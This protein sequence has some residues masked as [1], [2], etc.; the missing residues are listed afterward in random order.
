MK[1]VK[2]DDI[3]IGDRCRKDMGDIASLA[4][5]IQEVGLLQPP[6][7]TP[8]LQLVAGERRLSALRQLGWTDVPVNVAENLDNAGL[9]LKAERD[10]NIQR[11]GLTLGEERS[12]RKKLAK[13]Y[14]PDADDRRDRSGSKDKETG[15]FTTVGHCPD[16]EEKGRV[17]EKVDEV[18]GG[19][20]YKT[21]A[22]AEEV[23]V[24]A[25]EDPEEW[26]ELAEEMDRTGNAAGA[27]NELKKRRKE[28]DRATRAEA[29]STAPPVPV[30]DK[31]KAGE[32]YCADIRKLDLPEASVGLVFTD[33]PYHDEYLDLYGELGRVAAKALRPGG[34]CLSY[35]GGM[36][37][38]DVVASLC[39]A[40]L[41]YFW[42]FA[43]FHP[44]SKTKINRY[45]LFQNWRSVLV[46][47]KGDGAQCDWVQDVVRG[48]RNKENHDWAQDEEAP[49]QYI[50][51]YAE[52]EDVVL[53]P[54]VGG[55]TTVKVCHDIGQP[56]LGFDIDEQNV[57]LTRGGVGL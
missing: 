37:L 32:V 45:H 11:R 10:E 15:R 34:F 35:C 42:Q 33:P 29:V 12:V 8:D 2:I 13:I 51:V 22:R 27:L 9:L 4:N 53:D 52:P 26:G 28:E 16:V 1:T 48:E 17:R 49:R 25:E 31:Y 56:F 39:A 7:V 54:F 38:P 6:V 47:R 55:G 5:S 20:S 36:F 24:A 21:M 46:F 44:Y 41:T 3:T 50:P 57:Q 18:V 43:V 14:K 23:F 40:G 19:R 30:G